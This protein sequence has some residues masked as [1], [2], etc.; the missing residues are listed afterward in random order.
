MGQPAQKYPTETPHFSVM[1]IC[2]EGN[3]N[4]FSGD[5]GLGIRDILA[6]LTNNVIICDDI[7]PK[8]KRD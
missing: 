5:W 6:K 3:Q 2:Q 8:V 1:M 7:A 4:F